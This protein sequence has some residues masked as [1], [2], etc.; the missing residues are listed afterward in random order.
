MPYNV[1]YFWTFVA[2]YTRNK[3]KR[4]D[5]AEDVVVAKAIGTAVFSIATNPLLA[6]HLE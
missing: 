4:L 6:L 3:A 2:R 1:V 5:L